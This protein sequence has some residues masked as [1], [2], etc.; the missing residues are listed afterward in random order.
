MMTNDNVSQWFLYEGF[1]VLW[2]R[3]WLWMLA[4][5]C[6]VVLFCGVFASSACNLADSPLMAVM[7]LIGGPIAI[8]EA[9]LG[10]EQYLCVMALY[11]VYLTLL[12]S[13][14]FAAKRI[15]RILL[16]VIMLLVSLV[17]IYCACGLIWAS[18]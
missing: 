12:F 18:C 7:T 3:L 4:H 11:L 17:Y 6:V 5:L 13:Y 15:V 10:H 16:F 1:G 8:V 9:G 2:R 14:L